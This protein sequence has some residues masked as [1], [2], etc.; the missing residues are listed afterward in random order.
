MRRIGISL[1][2]LLFIT[3]SCSEFQQA[4]KDAKKDAV[5]PPKDNYIV[6]LD[7]SDRI[8][9]DNQQQIS[10]DL[11]VIKTIF[12]TFKSNINSKDPMH[13]YFTVNDKMKVLVAPQISTPSRV[14]EM[15][16]QLRVELA[17]EQ[18]QEKAALVTESEKT[19]NTVLP[20]LY[21]QAVL[22]KTSAAYSGADI[23]KYFEE[24][25]AGDLDNTA[26]NTLFII[27]D[28]YMDFEKGIE[29]PQQ[30]NR[31]TSISLIINQLK[32]D[33]EWNSKFDKEDFGIITLGKKFPNLRIVLLAIDPKQ[34][35]SGEYN[36]LTRIWG[37]WFSEM[38]VDTFSFVKNDNVN[39]IKESIE[40]FMQVNI[41]GKMQP[42]K[43]TAVLPDSAS[44]VI[45]ETLAEAN[46]N[47]KSFKKK[48]ESV[49]LANGDQNIPGKTT[50]KK[51]LANKLIKNDQVSFGPAY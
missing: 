30:N 11:T 10:K 15:A 37:K 43:W 50:K 47:D 7:L 42:A 44:H 34:E 12:E 48:D 26:T 49:A 4:V 27:T 9:R 13:L 28:G 29:R 25:L 24:D 32:K 51:Q 21:K 35:W 31:F 45:S 38:G 33:P 6:L 40:K 22:G 46:P 39:E 36:L 23:W 41:S 1:S 14:Y 18:P 3:A 19:F 16:G 8:L 17:A 20:E 2:I 5:P